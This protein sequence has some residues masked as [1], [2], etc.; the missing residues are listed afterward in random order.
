MSLPPVN[1]IPEMPMVVVRGEA[2]VLGKVRMTNAARET[3]AYPGHSATL[4]VWSSPGGGAPAGLLY[5]AAPGECVLDTDTG[6]IAV[7]VP[8][9]KTALWAFT[10]AR[11]VLKRLGPGAASRTLLRLLLEVQ[12]PRGVR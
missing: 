10:R 2:L 9:S 8:G 12:P 3:L 11:G 7:H 1:Q 4:E 5:T 6:I